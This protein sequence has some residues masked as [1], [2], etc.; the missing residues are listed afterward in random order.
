[1]KYTAKLSSNKK[2]FIKNEKT[3][4]TLSEGKNYINQRTE[5]LD[6]LSLDPVSDLY[7]IDWQIGDEKFTLELHEIK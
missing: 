7:S 6:T 1:M 4:L 5:E 2:G 3:G